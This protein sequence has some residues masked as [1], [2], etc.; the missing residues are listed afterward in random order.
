MTCYLKTLIWCH[1]RLSDLGCS[2]M[3]NLANHG[4]LDLQGA[5]SASYYALLRG[6]PQFWELGIGR[7]CLS[8]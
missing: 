5:E 4:H 1:S 2:E 8:N 3:W 6:C 7:V